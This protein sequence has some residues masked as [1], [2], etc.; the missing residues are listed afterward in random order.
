MIV[1]V[2]T[3]QDGVLVGTR[4]V[5]VP[6]PTPEQVNRETIEG[7]AVTALTSN[8]AYL[9]IP[10]PTQ[11][12]GFEQIEALTRQVNKIIRLVLGRLDSTE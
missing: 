10:Q 2:E 4:E 12:Q 8:A 6:D 1:I 3:W 9:A 11:L 7:Q 5:E